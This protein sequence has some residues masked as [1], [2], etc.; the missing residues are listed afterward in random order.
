M[1]NSENGRLVTCDLVC[2]GAT[3]PGLWSSFLAWV[4]AR[5]GQKVVGYDFRPKRAGVPLGV[6]SLELSDGTRHEGD[7][8]GK[9]W[10][11]IFGSGA[12]FRPSCHVCPYTVLERTG[13]F[14]LGDFW[15]V[16][17]VKKGIDDGR[18]VSL[19]L[20][21]L[22]SSEVFFPVDDA[23]L[24]PAQAAV[25][26]SQPALSHSH[27]VSPSRPAFWSAYVTGGFAKAASF[28]GVGTSMNTLKRKVKAL[29]ASDKPAKTSPYCSIFDA[30]LYATGR[31]GYTICEDPLR[32]TGCSACMAVCPKEAIAMVPNA[33][34]FLVPRINPDKCVSCG[35]CRKACPS[36]GDAARALK[37]APLRAYAY[38]NDDEVRAHSSS[39]GAF[40]ALAKPVIDEGG[41]VYGAAFD[42]RFAVRHIRCEDEVSLRR[43][44][45][46]KYVQSDVGD[47]Y[48]S[49]RADLASGRTVLFS[50][51]PCQV[52]GLKSY[53]KL[54]SG[55][56]SPQLI[57]VDL[58]CHGAASPGLFS[59]HVAFLESRYGHLTGFE[60]RNKDFGWHGY[61]NA[62]VFDGDGKRFGYDVSAYQE[63]FNFSY[64]ARPACSRCPYACA[65]RTGD[66]TLGDYWGV[67]RYCPS[68]DD[69]RGVSL[70]IACTDHGDSLVQC[71]GPAAKLEEGQYG[72]RVLRQPCIPSNDRTAFWNVYRAGGYVAAIK[73]FTRYGVARRTVRNARK[74]LR[75]LTEKMKGLACR[76]SA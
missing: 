45:G 20:A 19:V 49:V 38:R 58:L 2:A 55:G 68:I 65:E 27:A 70:V 60:F 72:Q 12:A 14:T 11:N 61:R 6:E 13:D 8:L 52:A 48:A 28:L 47:S 74:A 36:N 15:G 23:D 37:S 62:A 32:C 18:G 53:L 56:G 39:G 76:S 44:C 9:T 3:S 40:W 25:T 16:D 71:I 66:V 73:R 29:I 42:D 59:D 33:E 63:V 57:L 1:P 4:E 67:E 35:R 5:T 31:E 17:K 64:A 43:C 22:T 34:G 24:L 7:V 69:N 41:V 51:T 26:K 75:G 54:C 10:R 46:S 30:S 21:P 50:G